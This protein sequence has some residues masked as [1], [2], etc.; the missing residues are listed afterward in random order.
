[1]ASEHNGVLAGR[2][3]VVTGAGRGLGRNIALALAAAGADVALTARTSADLEPLAAAIAAQGRR[4]LAVPADVTDP[5]QVARLAEQVGAAWGGLDILVN[6]AGTAA[7]HKFLTHP[8][9]LWHQMLLVNLT[10]V[11]YVTKAFL[12][13]LIGAGGGRI[14]NIASTAARVGDRYV[15]AYT[16]TKHGVLGLTR[17]LAAELLPQAITVNAICPGFLDTPLTQTSIQN[18]V[19]R[20]GLS[21]ADA[22]AALEQMS[23]QNRLIQPEE[24]AAVVV[25]LAQDSSRGITGQAINV[26]GGGVMS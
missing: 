22:R 12:P 2:R 20:T 23:P 11:Y 5:A 1:M 6:N 4:S 24:V 3:A 14:I 18:I 7:S 16:A 10:S 26:D 13:L 25:F 9:D 17:A 21:E 8:D 15:A 19:A